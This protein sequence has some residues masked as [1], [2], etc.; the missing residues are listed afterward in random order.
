MARGTTAGGLCQ[1]AQGTGFGGSRGVGH[2]E[3]PAERGDHAPSSRSPGPVGVACSVLAGTSF[4]NFPDTC[5]GMGFSARSTWNRAVLGSSHCLA[6]LTSPSARMSLSRTLFL[7]K[8]LLGQSSDFLCPLP[9][10]PLSFMSLF[11][12]QDLYNFIRH[13][14][15]PPFSS[16]IS[17]PAPGRFRPLLPLAH[18]Q[19]SLPFFLLQPVFLF[20]PDLSPPDPLELEVLQHLRFFSPPF[21]LS[22]L[23]APR[24]LLWVALRS[25]QRLI[26]QKPPQVPR[27]PEPHQHAESRLPNHSNP[28]CKSSLLFY[29]EE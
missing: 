22:S 24:P 5:L 28:L 2:S 20:S 16:S 12:L 25:A 10:F 19:P 4:W 23:P 15:F 29:S 17:T 26:P 14:H 7:W 11:L 3:G 27:W 13:L 18:P 6:P 9:C 21:L 1:W 8:I